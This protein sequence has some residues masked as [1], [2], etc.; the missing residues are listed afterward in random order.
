MHAV[1]TGARV[2]A[3]TLILGAVVA[4]AAVAAPGA[5]AA[6]LVVG[7]VAPLTGVEATQGRAYAAGLQI[8]FSQFNAAGGAAG[9]TLSLVSRDDG[10]RPDDT[11]A[12]TRALLAE[13]RPLA[14]AGYF[15][16]R[17]ITAVV[18][19]GLLDKEKIPLVGYRAL[20]LAAVSPQLFTVRAG[21]PDQ[22][23][24]IMQH[25][26][27][28]GIS[29]VAVFMEAG[30]QAA[31][32]Q[33]TIAQ[34]AAAQ[35]IKV[36][37]TALQ[38]PEVRVMPAVT[39]IR[40]AQ[41][42]AVLLL[43]SVASAAFVESFRSEGGGAQLFATSD[44]DVEQL[45]KRL[46]DEQ[47]AG[48]SIAQVTPNPNKLS[49]RLAREFQQARKAAKV[50]L[51]ASHAMMEGYVAGRVLSEAVRRAGATPTRESVARA[52]ESIDR[53]DLGDYVVGFKPGENRGSR[54][55]DL[56]IVSGGQLKQ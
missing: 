31:G 7:Q 51:P 11:V 6:V 35:K 23:G 1:D 22:L 15:G 5:R 26:A 4:L 49:T 37:A 45:A 55:V 13:Q 28:M 24:K 14:L 38:P 12:A 47:L 10:S 53:L 25:L 19:S 18:E 42:Q 39:Q 33:A 54:Y 50:E 2:R 27:T 29:R 34:A 44:I 43:A 46:G 21:L 17:G 52:I 48:I 8:A 36:V 41:P 16:T 3:R 56:S 9:N 32:V 40:E 30:P 20:Q